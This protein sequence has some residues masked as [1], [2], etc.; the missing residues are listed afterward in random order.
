MPVAYLW[1]KVG[2]NIA[3]VFACVL[4]YKSVASNNTHSFICNALFLRAAIFLHASTAGLSSHTF[5]MNAYS[6]FADSSFRLKVGN[7]IHMRAW[8]DVLPA[9]K[10]N[11]EKSLYIAEHGSTRKLQS[12]S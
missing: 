2:K 12:D 8:A 11:V 6:S 1:L 7:N 4:V 5:S 9:S 3:Y 10:W